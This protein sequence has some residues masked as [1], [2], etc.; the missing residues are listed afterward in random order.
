M[1]YIIGLHERMI[2][3]A[4][5]FQTAQRLKSDYFGFENLEA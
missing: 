1:Q 2:M 5:Q 3:N 4:L